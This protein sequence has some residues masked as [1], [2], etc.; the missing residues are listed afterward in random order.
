[1]KILQKIG[2]LISLASLATAVTYEY[3]MVY[4]DTRTMG[5]GGANIAIGGEASS[6]FSNPAG[7]SGLKES[8]GME[9]EIFNVSVAGSAAFYNFAMDLKDN[10]GLATTDVDTFITNMNEYRQSNFHISVNDYSSV[11]L[12]GEKYAVSIGLLAGAEFNLLPHLS[13]GADGLMEMHGRSTVGTV[14]GFSYD[15][16]PELHLGAGYKSFKSYNKAASLN[17]VSMESMTSI[18]EDPVGALSDI[19]ATALDVGVIYDVEGVLDVLSVV[20]P[21]V[22]LSILN[23]GG[24]EMGD[25]YA[26]IPMSFNLGLAIQPEVPVL[27]DVKVAIDY[28]DMFNG[29]NSDTVGLDGSFMKRLRLGASASVFHNALFQLTGSVGMYNAAPTLGAQVRLAILEINAAMYTEETGAFAG[30][31]PDKR[32]QV[33][34]VI[35]F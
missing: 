15:V 22:A 2:L 6:I 23:I 14:L 11:S 25:Y 31:R 7:L 19:N 30:Q 29:Y 32:Y 3:P 10:M 12:R 34:F 8:E 9:L 21:T 13:L 27:E 24:I 35:G 18:M 16:L 4:K 28:I 20:K 1:M 33:S 26:S 5:M 17:I